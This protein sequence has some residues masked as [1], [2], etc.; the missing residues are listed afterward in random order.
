[1]S[2]LPSILLKAEAI[3]KSYGEQKLFQ[4]LF[5]SIAEG[6]S[7][8]IQ[9]RSGE[10]KSTLLHILAGLD[11]PTLGRLFFQGN[12]FSTKSLHI[13]RNR[14][15]G[16]VFQ[17]FHLLAERSALYNVLLPVEIARWPSA[18]TKCKWKQ[19]AD[20]LLKLVGLS[21]RSNQK[22]NTLSGG[23][24]QR[25]AIARALILRPPLL[26]LDEPTGNLDRVTADEIVNLLLSFHKE[27]IINS[28]LIV[29][30]EESI[31]KKMQKQYLLQ[32]RSLIQKI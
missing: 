3:T 26:F 25:V 5:F 6:E 24:K 18:Q 10:G 17:G 11:S 15:F 14:S 27:K 4:N 21:N 13:M 20:H 19:E 7:V 32:D 23:E 12:P 30:H 31:A 16:F 8:A 2:G 22:V 29:T 28:L 1:M 9:G